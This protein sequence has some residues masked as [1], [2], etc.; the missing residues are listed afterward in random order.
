MTNHNEKI[1][2]TYEPPSQMSFSSLRFRLD[3]QTTISDLYFD[4]SL[5]RET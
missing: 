2:A 1:N 4:V 5:K 3:T